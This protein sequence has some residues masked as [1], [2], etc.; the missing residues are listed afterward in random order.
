MK[1]FQPR[2]YV[3]CVQD[4][5]SEGAEYGVYVWDDEANAYWY[6]TYMDRSDAVKTAVRAMN[7]E[8]E[9]AGKAQIYDAGDVEIADDYSALADGIK[10]NFQH[11]MSRAE[12]DAC[13]RDAKTFQEHIDRYQDVMQ[14]YGDGDNWS[15][16][17]DAEDLRLEIRE[18]Y[19]LD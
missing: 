13:T 14:E 8:A 17:F 12:I 1:E 9:E 4:P 15:Q 19:G 2:S 18:N 3:E 7:R 5:R 16:D 11:N 6:S 10:D